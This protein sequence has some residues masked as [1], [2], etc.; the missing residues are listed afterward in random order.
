MSKAEMGSTTTD[1]LNEILGQYPTGV[2]IVTGIAGDGSPT[3]IVPPT[4]A[5]VST[6]PPVISFTVAA[7]SAS[8]AQL[9]T[10]KSFCVNLIA[11]DG[12]RMC[13]A[14]AASEA[15]GTDAFESV[16][17]RPA[18]TGAPILDGVLSWIECE[19]QDVIEVGERLIVLGRV[20]AHGADRG[21]IP[22]LNFQEGYGRFVPGALAISRTEGLGHL[23]V[24]I[25]AARD[26]LD[27]LARELAAE[28]TL[29][30]ASDGDLVFV[31]TSNYS[32]RSGPTRLGLR[33][34]IVPPIGAV[35]VDG[36][37]APTR[38]EW[39]ERLPES[40]D[41][42][43]ARAAEQLRLVRSR[44]WSI[45]LLGN[46]PLEDIDA[47]VARYTEAETLSAQVAQQRA[48]VRERTAT[49]E[50]VEVEDKCV[51]DVL[52]VSVPVRSPAGTVVG[53]L[54]LGDLPRGAF[55]SEVRFWIRQL[56]ETARTVEGEL[57]VR[58]PA[59]HV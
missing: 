7:T 44:G 11:A 46:S 16:P 23:P 57:A 58:A 24:L 48:I 17:W 56:V 59:F 6:Q 9:R 15:N 49:Y 38:K 45:S 33:A 5:P 34:P 4:F 31:A 22:L 42:V 12:E 51:Y 47:M 19:L 21:F 3:G 27:G 1:T 54:R 25:D 52:Q 26:H 20:L 18:R 8:F 43:L 13:R 28:C 39:I 37:G 30:V 32:N 40:S 50:L 55:G 14:F 2:V 29:L 41:T 36:A 53:A 10:G 35:F